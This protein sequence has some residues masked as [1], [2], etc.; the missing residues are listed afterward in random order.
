MQTNRNRGQDLLF[1]AMAY[2]LGGIFLLTINT[3]LALCIFGWI[4]IAF[5]IFLIVESF[6]NRAIPW[7][8][9]IHTLLAGPLF[10]ATA[11]D[12]IIESVESQQALYIILAAIFLVLLLLAILFQ[13][14]R[15][16]R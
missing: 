7:G 10:L 8:D 12:F 14:F 9:R 3:S 13:I 15:V 2:A 4:F 16:F 5:A 6:F 11:A 1:E